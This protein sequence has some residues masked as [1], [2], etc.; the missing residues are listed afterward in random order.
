MRFRRP[1]C[2]SCSRRRLQGGRMR[3]RWCSRMKASAM[4]RSIG[5]PTGGRLT[6]AR[7]VG[8]ETVVGLCLARSLDMIVGLIG[9]LKAGGA[10]VPLDPE[11]P[12]ARLEYMVAEAGL[13]LLLTQSSLA[14]SLTIPAGV[15]RVLLDLEDTTG[16]PDTAPS[17]NLHP[18]HLVY[19][20]FTSGSTGKPKGAANTHGGLHNRMSWMQN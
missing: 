6:R 18:E 7:G 13:R 19:L 10:Y 8:P 14:S 5:A 17:I 4:A 1:L 12:I 3:L 20:I 11:Y 15:K 9:I 16:Q 2:R